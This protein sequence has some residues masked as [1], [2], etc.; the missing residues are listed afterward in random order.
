MNLK[1]IQTT[2]NTSHLSAILPKNPLFEI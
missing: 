2:T 1:T